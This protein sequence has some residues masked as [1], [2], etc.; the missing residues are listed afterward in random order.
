[1]LLDR[2]RNQIGTDNED[3]E[4]KEQILVDICANITSVYIGC[5]DKIE[6]TFG[7][8]VWAYRV[9]PEVFNKMPP[10][11]QEMYKRRAKQW[12]D[13]RESIKSLGSK[14]ID[15]VVDDLK[16]VMFLAKDRKG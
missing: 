4:L 10:E 6:Q 16:E 9:V 14:V 7:A 15:R 5:F 8:D 13:C 3:Q 11:E 12:N 1:M 2:I